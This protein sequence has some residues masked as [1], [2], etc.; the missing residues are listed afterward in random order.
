[1]F[2]FL[3]KTDIVIYCQ[4]IRVF[5]VFAPIAKEI[6]IKQ[7]VR[8]RSG[9]T[10]LICSCERCNQQYAAAFYVVEIGSILNSFWSIYIR[11]LQTTTMH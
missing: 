6:R 3:Q 4:F 8:D 10:K 11:S 7:K 1:M 5:L 9:H 2:F